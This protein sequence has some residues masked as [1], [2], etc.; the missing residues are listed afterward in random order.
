MVDLSAMQPEDVDIRDIAHGLSMQ[1]RYNGQCS[2]FYSVAEHS[3]A[4]AAHCPPE[5]RLAGLLHDAA[6]AYC[7]DIARP[8]KEQFPEIARFEDEVQHR[9][10]AGLGLP[11]W[12]GGAG[13][14]T[15]PPA[16]KLAD[17]RM[18]ATEAPQLGV[19]LDREFEPYRGHLVCCYSP[20]TA[21]DRFLRVWQ[22]LTDHPE[23]LSPDEELAL[24]LA[25]AGQ[26]GVKKGS[27]TGEQ[28]TAEVQR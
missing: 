8:I 28:G 19:K 27:G 9:V 21:R 20:V 4:V 25:Y 17:D 10:L 18:L 23:E 1:C 5:L 13:D 24:L 3:V 15:M 22:L 16:V 12:N 14:E 26:D 7:G 6:E 2:R 11:W